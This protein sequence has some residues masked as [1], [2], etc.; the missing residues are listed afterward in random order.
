ME[1]FRH[2]NKT[3]AYRLNRQSKAEYTVGPVR[4]DP[5]TTKGSK[6]RVFADYLTDRRPASASM[7]ALVCWI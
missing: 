4:A 5:K 3:F 1:R 7:Y 2:P 6:L